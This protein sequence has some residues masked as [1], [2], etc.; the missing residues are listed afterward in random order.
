MS[1]AHLVIAPSGG[2][3]GGGGND[4]RLTY[5]ALTSG[6]VTSASTTGAEVTA[7]AMATSTG[8]YA[9]TYWLTVQTETVTNGC[10]F[11]VNHDG[12]ATPHG[13]LLAFP[14]SA[15][16]ADGI[17]T[18]PQAFPGAAARAFSTT[19]PNLGPT[20]NT[21]SAAAD[22]PY[23]VTATIHVTGAGNVELWFASETTDDATLINNG[24]WG[25]LEKVG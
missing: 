7:L 24:C 12:T 25:R 14:G 1:L 2:T 6:D 4:P 13:I 18:V 10:K 17:V 23:I 21:D 8:L 16:N 22:V 15:A 11:G 19:A 3:G 20:A 9:V 5:V